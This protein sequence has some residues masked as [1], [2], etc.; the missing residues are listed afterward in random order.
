MEMEGSFFFFKF[1][2]VDESS[3][4]RA[5]VLAAGGPRPDDGRRLQRWN[6]NLKVDIDPGC[7]SWSWNLLGERSRK[8]KEEHEHH[9][10]PEFKAYLHL[11][12]STKPFALGGGSTT[13]R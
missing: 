13:L 5:P 3:E 7:S 10:R 2:D 9:H 1:A 11:F 12:R 6:E 8:E 4:A